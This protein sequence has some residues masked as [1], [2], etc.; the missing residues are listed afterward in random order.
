MLGAYDQNQMNIK[1]RFQ[2]WPGELL[3]FTVGLNN[4][5]VPVPQP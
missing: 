1:K 5:E 4:P 2:I 3:A